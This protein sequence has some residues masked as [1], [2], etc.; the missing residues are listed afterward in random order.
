MKYDKG[1]IMAEFCIDCMNKMNGSNYTEKDVCFSEN[2]DLCEG[3]GEYKHVVI[4]V[5][6]GKSIFNC[7]F[8]NK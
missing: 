3:C 2:T 8:G 1:V 5:K 4:S 7:L 6:E